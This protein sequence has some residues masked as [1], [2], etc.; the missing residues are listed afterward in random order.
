MI[1]K[2]SGIEELDKLF[3]SITRA[4]HKSDIIDY[5]NKLQSDQRKR[6][7]NK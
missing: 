1:K 3:R 7:K 6:E 4:K 5:Y 2:E